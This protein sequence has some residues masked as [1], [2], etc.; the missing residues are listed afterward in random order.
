MTI[1]MQNVAYKLQ[2]GAN[3]PYDAPDSWRAA[4]VEEP[5]PPALDW[6]HA[7]ARGVVADLTDRRGI[8]WG[9]DN[10]DPDIR[11]EIVASL[12]AIIR[13]AHEGKAQ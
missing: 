12:A 1:D 6:A 5:P 8:K 2:R 4:N 11:A 10:I 3:Y 7:A 9:F 13:L